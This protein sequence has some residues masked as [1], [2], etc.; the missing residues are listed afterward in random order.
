[1]L[2][3]RNVFS[4][5]LVSLLTLSLNQLIAQNASNIP[6]VNTKDFSSLQMKGVEQ[7]TIDVDLKG[8]VNRLSKAVQF[9]TISNQDRSDFDTIA[10][11]NYHQFIE[12]SYPLVHQTLTKEVLG[13]PRPYSLL[14]KWEGTNPNLQPALFY[15]HQD[16]VP[17]P[18]DSRDQWKEDPFSGVVKDGYIWG[19]GVLDDKNQIHAI[20]EAAEMKIKEG[21]QPSRTIYFV[22]GQDEEVG[23]AEGAK[24]V[25]DVL[26]ARGIERFAYV[27]DESAPLTPGIF[28]GIK[29][30]TA[31]IGIAQKGFISLELKIDGIGGHSSM[32]PEESNI[33][34]LATAITKLEKAQFPYKIH[35]AVRHQYR[36][37]GP[38]LEETKKPLYAAIAFGKEDELTDYE[39]QF[40]EEM[41]TNEVTRAMLH[42]TIATTMFNAGIKD[43]VLPPTATAVVNF[44]PMPGD[45]P[46]VI[47][48]HVKK[49]INDDR[50]NIKNISASTP[51]TNI[52]NPNSDAY[53][54]LEKTIHQTWGNDLIVSPFFVV[55]G[56]DSKHF[57]ARDFAPDVYTITAIQLENT[58]E[59][60]G[61]HGV[62]ERI[63]IKEYG[64]SIGFF[65]QMFN[66]LELMDY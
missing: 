58:I 33:G 18:A 63:L 42:T 45:T 64:K 57:Q 4:V 10:F 50:I 29:D 5:V 66:N 30:N 40:I 52:A 21:W 19:R 7:I 37:M 8:A 13:D 43:N 35:P 3:V 12:E 44:R 11:S 34:I 62:N 51:A 23:G 28:P 59:F 26:E 15:A 31:L 9:K 32:P 60:K 56:S 55:G 20:L 54:A 6:T 24:V 38:E 61:F 16:V 65:Y 25:A 47:I 22:F 49:A 1:M 39:K 46:E 14:Y 41:S 27:M 17:V 2:K 36:Y 53:K 48:E